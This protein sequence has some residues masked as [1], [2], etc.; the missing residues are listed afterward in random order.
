MTLRQV[1]VTN[2]VDKLVCD[3]CG[4]EASNEVL[5]YGWFEVNSELFNVYGARHFCRVKCIQDVEAF[6][7]PP[8]GL[9]DKEFE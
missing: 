5:P 3:T 7:V 6:R 8:N 4:R 1:V 2:T 9:D